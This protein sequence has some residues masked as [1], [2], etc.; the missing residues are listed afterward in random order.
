M[1]LIRADID[2]DLF[3]EV[4][5]VAKVSEDARA[6]QA[7]LDAEGVINNAEWEQYEAIG[8]MT[9]LKRRQ[10]RRRLGESIRE[11]WDNHPR[12]V[13]HRAK[14]PEADLNVAWRALEVWGR[15]GLG[16]DALLANRDN[17]ISDLEP[18]DAEAG[19]RVLD[20]LARTPNDVPHAGA[21]YDLPDRALIDKVLHVE[22]ALAGFSPI[23]VILASF[24]ESE[25]IIAVDFARDDPFF[26]RAQK[27]RSGRLSYV[28]ILETLAQ[29]EPHELR[30]RLPH[31][32]YLILH[33]RNDPIILKLLGREEKSAFP[34]TD[35]LDAA[36][37]WPWLDGTSES[38]VVV[39]LKNLPREAR[40]RY[41][42]GY[43]LDRKGLAP[44]DDEQRDALADFCELDERLTSELNQVWLQR[45]Y[46]A[47]LGTA[48]LEDLGTAAEIIRLRAAESTAAFGGS[49]DLFTETDAVAAEA[50][51]QIL[52]T[53]TT[54]LHTH[55]ALEKRRL[56]ALKSY[57][58]TTGAIAEY[59]AMTAAIAAGIIATAA[60]GGTA[61]PV[62]AGLIGAAATASTRIA[63]KEV[64]LGG[65]FSVFGDE[66]FQEL[67][68]GALEGAFD[69]LTAGLGGKLFQLLKM[70]KF[71]GKLF[72]LADEAIDA[73]KHLTE[74][75]KAGGRETL[76]RLAT[77]GASE[78][79]RGF[80]KKG[81][82]E[83]FE[84]IVTGAFGEL[85]AA[86]IDPETYDRAFWDV[87]VLLGER[88]L[89]GG[90][91][92]G[93]TGGTL[94]TAFDF[95]G[96]LLRR[97]APE[98]G[99]V[100]GG[101]QPEHGTKVEVNVESVDKAA[102]EGLYGKSNQW[103]IEVELGKGE[104]PEDAW[105]FV[106]SST[107]NKQE[108]V[109]EGTVVEPRAGACFTA[110]TRVLVSSGSVPIETLVVGDEVLA[111]VGPFGTMD[112][113]Q[114][115]IYDPGK[116]SLA[117]CKVRPLRGGSDLDS[118]E[119][120]ATITNT[121]V[122][123]VDAVIAVDLAYPEG[124]VDTLI[125]TPNHPFW[126]PTER[127]YV[128]LEDVAVGTVLRTVG[129]GRA[130]V[131]AKAWRH[132]EVEVYDVEVEGL[133]CF[134]AAGEGALDGMGVL[135]HNSVETRHR[136][137][138]HVDEIEGESAQAIADKVEKSGGDAPEPT[139][140]IPNELA[141]LQNK[142][143]N[144]TDAKIALKALSESGMTVRVFANTWGLSE[145]KLYY[146]KRK[147]EASA[148]GQ[149]TKKK[150]S[151][152][153]DIPK[154]QGEIDTDSAGGAPADGL[155]DGALKAISGANSELKKRLAD[156][157]GKHATGINTLVVRPRGRV[158]DTSAV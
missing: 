21:L 93:V 86:G 131:A 66:G 30:Y 153:K 110:G 67:V 50:T 135:V 62:A 150:R 148:K 77:G 44:A 20:A 122:R 89:V 17:A 19:H 45:A 129:G 120:L 151:S 73:S 13:F 157:T 99:A 49:A 8:R 2:R 106:P 119:V 105:G 18:T 141:K 35:L 121:F 70:R 29:M 40:K 144:K 124:T 24:G 94:G 3:Q 61:G 10:Q 58:Q 79:I 68:T 130:K 6:E 143:W 137:F 38:L 5:T 156:W 54:Q 139:G 117:D 125:G 83:T 158:P 138:G 28:E 46:D 71:A 133:H 31:D 51:A 140:D 43:R 149:G 41:R 113:G 75:G 25:R 155:S 32:I 36:F 92:G 102:W 114:E 65:K 53:D 56:Q 95:V 23:E 82:E 96:T 90:A 111:F 154:Q 98:V 104:S 134:Y 132:G 22:H 152:K 101:G 136:D 127:R 80:L 1:G 69:V 84:G 11:A 15:A 87:L 146:W 57:V 12:S 72:G 108:V 78:Q 26:Q 100:P 115:G 59:A 16:V 147:I 97:A 9:P 48:P 4:T 27:L 55:A 126:V 145:R 81:A 88:A 74:V 37:G 142:R 34:S 128:M 109:P 116:G 85:V 52:M 47:L 76:A 118:D 33:N 39:A 60:T 123:T 14:L 7:I 42:L 91:V 64:L 112:R 103:E 107:I 63:T